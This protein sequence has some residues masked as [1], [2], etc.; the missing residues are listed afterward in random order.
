MK[1]SIKIKSCS[2]CFSKDIGFET[3][4]GKCFS[5]KDYPGVFITKGDLELITCKA[6]GEIFTSTKYEDAKNLDKC[7]E[8]SI[9]HQVGIFLSML[10]SWNLSQRDVCVRLGVTEGYLSKVKRGIEIPAFGLFNSLKT[11]AVSED[12]MKTSDPS[13]IPDVVKGVVA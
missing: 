4:K 6:C 3:V 2:N 7:I 9:T 11:M 5:Y 1:R 8:D 12:A 10:K 13:F